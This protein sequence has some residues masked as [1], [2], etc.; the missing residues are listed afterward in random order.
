[1]SQA[2]QAAIDR[3]KPNADVAGALLALLYKNAPLGSIV[4][5]TVASILYWLQRGLSHATW[6]ALWLAYMVL[7]A[8][9]RYWLARAY[10]RRHREI[11][12]N[13][14]SADDD[15]ARWRMRFRLGLSASCAGWVAT[16]FL[17]LPSNEPAYQLTTATV[18]A[19]MAAG[20]VGVLSSDRVSIIIMIV[21][22]VLLGS[23]VMFSFNTPI[24]IGFGLMGLLISAGLGNSANNMHV[25]LVEAL[26]LA[27][28]KSRIADA[29]ET[30][31]QSIAQNNLW[32]ENEINER[33]K[34]E[35]ALVNAKDAAE[36]ANRAK[37]AFLANMSHELR[38]PLN[39]IVGFVDLLGTSPLNAEQQ[40]Q[41]RMI[42]TSADALHDVISDVLDFSKIE[43][44]RMNL[45]IA[46]VAITPLLTTSLDIVRPKATTKALDLIL[47]I[48]PDMPSHIKTDAVKLRQVLL[49]FLGNAVKFSLTGEVTLTATFATSTDGTG[50]TLTLIIR[51]T[52]IG[53]TAE[54]LEKIFHPFTQAD[55]S[56]TRRF[57]G[58]GLGLS[59]SK[60]LIAL[61]NGTL[62]LESE[63]GVG[64][65]VTV[66]LP[67]EV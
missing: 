54:T 53:M 63:T 41:V 29:L 12:S 17:F 23:L 39:G 46:S 21:S 13:A 36:A 10:Q 49:N 20:G 15:I 55:N 52:G 65:V 14:D 19:G 58:T 56:D 44:G 35:S 34:V 8:L 38:T 32:L 50:G 24:A 48:A 27:H 51:D 2:T 28:E 3:T 11:P 64:T 7:A 16:L 62:T 60:Q 9:G 37:S 1:M 40:Q 33:I 25:A 67:V 59:I 6:A 57:G 66:C 26:Y 61:M 42:K 31:N 5:V 22:T 30:A 47:N 4:I 45:H 18:L 43:A